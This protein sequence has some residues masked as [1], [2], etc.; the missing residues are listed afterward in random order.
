MR[1]STSILYLT[2]SACIA[3]L[4]S[5]SAGDDEVMCRHTCA[6]WLIYFVWLIGVSQALNHGSGKFC[7]KGGY[8][9]LRSSRNDFETPFDWQIVAR[10]KLEQSYDIMSGELAPA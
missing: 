4:D 8:T 10:K 5:A 3:V 7:Q 9:V 2:L 6:T 1:W